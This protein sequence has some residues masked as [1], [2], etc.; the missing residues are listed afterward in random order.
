MILTIQVLV[1]LLAVVAAVAVLA[2]RSKIP[3]AILL[4]L[5]GVLFALIPGL[6]SVDLAP[7]LVLLLILPPFI[8]TSAFQM[9]WREFHFSLRPI[10]LLSV[11]SVVFTTVTVAAAVHALMDIEWPVGFVLGAIVSP[12]DAVAPLSIARRLQIPRRIIVVL[13]GEGLAN[14]ATALVLYRFAIVA[15][16]V[17]SFSLGQ[18]ASTFVAIVAGEILWGIGVGWLMLRLRRWVHDPSIEI[19]LSVLTPFLA[20]WPPEHMGGSGVLATVTAGLYISWNGLRLIS[21][22]TRLQG[23][24]FWDF[25]TYLIEG[26]VFLITGLQA[27]TLIA[28]IGDYSMSELAI[29]A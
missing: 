10:A 2:N 19:T 22:A 17:G 16:S 13:E 29:S 15:V 1:L 7:E 20:Y 28:R 3:P 5:A 9:S 11:G 12:P 18:A 27:R 8:Y 23:V 14:D 24:F 25:L 26:M 21:A 6:P 4:V